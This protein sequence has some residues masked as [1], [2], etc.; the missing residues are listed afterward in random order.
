MIMQSLIEDYYDENN[1]PL[2]ING[3][4]IYESQLNS[5]NTTLILATDDLECGVLEAEGELET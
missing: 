3:G 5:A 2:E 1:N 4:N